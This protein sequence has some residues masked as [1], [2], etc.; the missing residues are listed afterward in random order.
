MTSETLKQSAKIYQFQ[1]HS[2]SAI[3]PGAF[4]K[5]AAPIR[6]VPI[7]PAVDFGSGW[8]HDEAISE[9]QPHRTR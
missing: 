6:E 4:R 5:T 2:R 3:G 9:G 1:A 8:Y 7:V